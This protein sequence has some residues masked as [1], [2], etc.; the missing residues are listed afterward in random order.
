MLSKVV[1]KEQLEV[2]RIDALYRVCSTDI[3]RDSDLIGGKRERHVG[4][5]RPAHIP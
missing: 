1:A 5:I 4:H 3:G 2:L